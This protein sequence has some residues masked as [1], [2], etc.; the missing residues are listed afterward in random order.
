[1]ILS[2]VSWVEVYL[3]VSYRNFSNNINTPWYWWYCMFCCV[4]SVIIVN[5]LALSEN[6]KIPCLWKNVLYP[7]GLILLYV[8]M[9]LKIWGK[10]YFKPSRI[11]SPLLV[12][13][14]FF[15]QL[16]QFLSLLFLILSCGFSSHNFIS[17]GHF[18]FNYHFVS[19]FSYRKYLID[20]WK[21]SWGGQ[22]HRFWS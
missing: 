3:N 9:W 13:V 22:D 17:F 14:I 1:M 7:Q 4:A 19:F 11:L 6:L 2:Q 20:W 12:F 15:L 18:L 21:Y 5:V 10:M 16:T 8:L